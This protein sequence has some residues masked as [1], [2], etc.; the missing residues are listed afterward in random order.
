MG[1]FLDTDID[2]TFSPFVHGPSCI[3]I[4]YFEDTAEVKA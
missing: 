3:R 1:S 2:P 4:I